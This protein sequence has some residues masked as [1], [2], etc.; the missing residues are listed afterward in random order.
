[1]VEGANALNQVSVICFESQ[2]LAGS[3][4]DQY[5]TQCLGRVFQ[6]S[7]PCVVRPGL[8]IQALQQ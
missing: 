5:K 8:N 2:D 3:K 4:S 7:P 1:M 6:S